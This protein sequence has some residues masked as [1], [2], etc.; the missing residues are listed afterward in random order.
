MRPD[1]VVIGCRDPRAE[2]IMLEIYS[3][4]QRARVPFVTT[5]VESAELIKYASNG[6]LAAKI[7]FIN[8][9]AR[10][11]EALGA[12]VETVAKGMGLDGRIGPKFLHAGPGLRRLLLPQGHARRQP[13]G[14]RAG[15]R[16]PD[17]RGGARG[18]PGDPGAHGRQ[19]ARRPRRPRGEDR[20]A[21]GAVVQARDRRH[22]RVAGAVRAR[23]P[24]G[25]RRHG[26]RLRSG[27]DGRLPRRL[28][29]G[30]VLRRRLR[31]RRR[32]RR[33]GHLHRVERVPRP[34]A[35]AAARQPAAA[36]DRRPAQ[37]LRAG[38]NGRRRLPLRLGRP[39]GGP[40][41]RRSPAT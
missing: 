20:G 13:H 10:L 21:A 33:A 18:Q 11:C 34:R 32:R 26:A 22:P 3:P 16:V 14:A 1:R 9:I 17:H 19:D 2:Q 4:L 37:H 36:A 5:S 27:G 38:A 29:A 35:G 30:R 12:D 25:R 23:R 15:L 6:F 41:R 7:S 24:A 31:G 39:A 40:D 28:P 8:E